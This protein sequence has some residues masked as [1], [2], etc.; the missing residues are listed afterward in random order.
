MRQPRSCELPRKLGRWMKSWIPKLGILNVKDASWELDRNFSTE[1]KL[2]RVSA[3]EL[4]SGSGM[5]GQ[6]PPGQEK[7]S[8]LMGM[9]SGAFY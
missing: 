1:A 9:A 2:P 8:R 3:G 7:C 6:R 5:K 4:S